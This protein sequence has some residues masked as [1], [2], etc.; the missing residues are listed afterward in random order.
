[1]SM[2]VVTPA[3]ACAPQEQISKEEQSKIVN[4]ILAYKT[5]EEGKEIFSTIDFEIDWSNA[6]LVKHGNGYMLSALTEKS[7]LISNVNGVSLLYDGSKVRDV[8]LIESR[9]IA[10]GFAV[11]SRSLINENE[12]SDAIIIKDNTGKAKL[13]VQ[14]LS[15]NEITSIDITCEDICKG[16]VSA[17]CSI[18][19]VLL[20]AAIC[21]PAAPACVFI[22]S[23]LYGLICVYSQ[24]T[25]CDYLCSIV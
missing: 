7:T 2:F 12:G 11:R 23:I 20:C 14:D 6:V 9:E 8:F 22:C 3:M 24:G 13:Y 25:D 18:G 1:M 16:I 5:T 4:K 21:G 19:A 10:N 15:T 17:G